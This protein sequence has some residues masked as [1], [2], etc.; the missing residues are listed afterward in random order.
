M[1]RQLSITVDPAKLS[2]FAKFDRFIDVVNR[3]AIDLVTDLRRT[4]KVTFIIETDD[5]RSA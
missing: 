2:S 5:G 3:E 4:A 1:K